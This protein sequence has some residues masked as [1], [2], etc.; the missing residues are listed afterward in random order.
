MLLLLPSFVSDKK[1][2]KLIA[3]LN[4]AGSKYVMVAAHRAGHNGYPENSLSAWKHAIETGVDIIETDVK[5]TRDSVVILMHDGK[6]NRTTNGTGNPED[7]TLAELKNF[8][9][10]MPD[11]TLTGETIP[12]F[13]EALTLAKG[14]IL[15]D[16]DIKTSRLKPVVDVV[17][18]TRMGSQVFYFDNDYDALRKVLSLEPGSVMMPRAYSYQM[19]DSALK[20]FA[21]RVVHIDESFYTPEL[22]GMIRSK[23][24]RVWINALGDPDE[25]IRAGNTG[26]AVTELLRYGASIIQTDE[27]ELLIPYLKSAGRR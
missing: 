10:K 1:A 15:V 13:E 16:I 25:Q 22:T 12:T 19:A 14:K 18:K 27:P 11:G 5:V 2:E 20:I 24:A 4:D 17:R 3:L 23:H 8:R 9:L 26:K 7:Y 21:A 6:I